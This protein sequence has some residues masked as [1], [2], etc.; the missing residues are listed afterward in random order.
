M[1]ELVGWCSSLILL[2]TIAIQNY[3]QWKERTSAGVS[4]WLFVGQLA[5]S[6]G[7]TI[8]S[9]MLGNWIFIITNALMMLNSLIGFGIVK[10]NKRREVMAGK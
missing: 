5:A 8:Y 6:I 2:L 7:F 10:L 9:W 3:K 1:T 4:I